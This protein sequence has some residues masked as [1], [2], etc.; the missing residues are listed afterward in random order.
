MINISGLPIFKVKRV[1]RNKPEFHQTGLRWSDS[2]KNTEIVIKQKLKLNYLIE[3]IGEVQHL[4][5]QK[6]T[7]VII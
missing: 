7:L 3:A 1:I 5:L 6:V 2:I 4:F